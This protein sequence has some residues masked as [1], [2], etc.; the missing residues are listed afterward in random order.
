MTANKLAM[1][2]ADAGHLYAALAS[3]SSLTGATQL[4]NEL[5]GLPQVSGG[6]GGGGEGEGMGSKFDI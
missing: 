6:G 5:S 1:S 4:N 2:V 3:S